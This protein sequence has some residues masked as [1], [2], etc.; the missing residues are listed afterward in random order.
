M[1]TAVLDAGRR[2]RIIYPT[3]ARLHRHRANL[4]QTLRT[5]EAFAG[6]GYDVELVMAPAKGEVAVDRRLAELGI[7]ALPGLRFDPLLHSGLKLWPYLLARWRRLRR[8]DAVYVRSVDLSVRL[9]RLRVPHVLEVHEVETTLARAGRLADVIAWQRAGLI[10]TLL[11]ISQGAA[12]RLLAAGADPAR[13]RVAPSGVAVEDFA[14]LAIP[15]VARLADPAVVHVGSL[16]P[17]R[18]LAVFQ[19]LA[20]A[21]VARL[22]LVGPVE[23]DAGGLDG[24]LRQDTVPHRDVPDWYGRG[25]IAVMPYQ[26]GLATAESFSPIKL[27]EALA[28]GRPVIASDMPVIREVVEH[29]RTAL[30]VRPD[31]IAGWVA[32]VRRIREDPELGLR[33]ARAGREL[34]RRYGWRE[35]A[36][37]IAAACGWP[38]L[39]EVAR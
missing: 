13:V 37:G 20:A 31:D 39:A 12:D 11:P 15:D 25:D 3:R 36:I 28:A 10:R 23:G 21:G 1:T 2:F 29:E 16:G 18:G 17:T 4:I 22:I 8:A 7:R 34:A 5:A 9:A 30:L 6:L 33:L 26:P 35:R 24:A 38:A 14:G 32:A 27:F 19:A